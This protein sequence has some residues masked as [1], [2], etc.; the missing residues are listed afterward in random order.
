MS[1]LPVAIQELELT[2]LKGKREDYLVVLNACLG[3]ALPRFTADLR[4]YLEECKIAHHSAGTDVS[5][6]PGLQIFQD[7]Y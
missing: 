3:D 6:H 1:R 4:I 2:A 5:N 7:L